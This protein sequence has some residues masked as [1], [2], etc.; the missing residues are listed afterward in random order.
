MISSD[1][2][3]PLIHW[4]FRPYGSFVDLT[5]RSEDSCLGVLDVLELGDYRGLPFLTH[6]DFNGMTTFAAQKPHLQ[7]AFLPE[8]A[9]GRALAARIGWSWR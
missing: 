2:L 8:R 5:P 3:L 7:E 4:G 9:R 1:F 6:Q